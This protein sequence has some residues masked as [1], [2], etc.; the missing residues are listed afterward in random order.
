MVS[1]T[2]SRKTLNEAFI[3]DYGLLRE[4][5][6]GLLAMCRNDLPRGIVLYRFTKTDSLIKI[7]RELRY[8]G[9]WWVPYSPFESLKQYAK[10]RGHTLCDAALKCLAIDPEWSDGKIDLLLKVV[11]NEPLSAWAGTP[12]TQSQIE[13]RLHDDD[14]RRYT[15][16]TFE[17]DRDITQ[18]FIPGLDRYPAGSK[19]CIGEIAFVVK[20]DVRIDTFGTEDWAQW[21]C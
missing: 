11:V 9:K 12:K 8:T 6:E 5:R 4:A 1:G 13:K 20:P 15:G 21:P 19:R 7:P 17:P 3:D 18:V 16:K 10:L 2:K 14:P